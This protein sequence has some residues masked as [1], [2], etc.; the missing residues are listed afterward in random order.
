[1]ERGSDKHSA[2]MDDAL[3]H[4]VA[5]MLSSGHDTH[6]EE[7]KSAEPSG[8]DQP[9]VDRM[10]DGTMS[11]GLP[12][13]LTGTDLQGRSRLAAYLGKEVWPATGEQLLEVARSRS[14]P[15]VVVDQLASLPPG[16]VFDNLQAAW[17]ELGG[18][19]EAHRS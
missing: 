15:D 4:E 10:P 6:A 1:M 17:T 19:V 9:D 7:W 18:G 13:G 2:R 5:G 3:E 16:R 12:D 11:G 14:A 8:E